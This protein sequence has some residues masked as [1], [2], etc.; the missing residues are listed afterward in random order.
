VTDHLARLAA[1]SIGRSTSAA[2]PA[3]LPVPSGSGPR[4]PREIEE[5]DNGEVPAAPLYDAVLPPAPTPAL[6]LAAPRR[7][8]AVPERRPPE[9]GRTDAVAGRDPVAP[10]TVTGP[11]GRPSVIPT[12]PTVPTVP[13][14]PS[15]ARPTAAAAGPAPAPPST[16][17]SPI[18]PQDNPAEEGPRIAAAEHR[19]APDRPPAS[20]T[21]PAAAA[22]RL[23]PATVVPARPVRPIEV[24]SGSELRSPGRDGSSTADEPQVIRVSIGRIEVRAPVPPPVPVSRPEGHGPST[25]SLDDYLRGRQHRRSIR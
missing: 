3:R 18:A 14:V 24:R 19:E 6:K 13:T 22:E 16:P 12:A 15:A 8:S 1:R 21:T 9:D 10:P 11:A 25:L 17:V 2:R 5:W 4:R 23:S 7:P 20:T